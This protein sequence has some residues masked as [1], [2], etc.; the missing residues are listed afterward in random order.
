MY[1]AI[2]FFDLDGTL[3]LNDKSLSP[4]VI[5]AIGQLKANNILPV[6]STG[7]NVFEVEYVL[8]QTG[9]NSIVSA[10]G[11]YVEYE[12][13]EL[14]AD[15]M[16][17]SVINEFNA[18]AKKQGDPVAWF[19][20]AEF[21]LSEETPVTDENFKLLSLD[22]RVIPDWYEKNA[23]NFLFVF[24][25][26]KEELYQER[27]AGKLSLVRNNPRGLDT[28]VAGVSKKT[29]IQQ[30]LKYSGLGEIPSYA[31][32]DQINDLEM[33]DQVDHPVAM[34]NGNPINKERAEFVTTSNMDNGI[35]NGLKHF[36]LI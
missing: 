18:F 5:E 29:G 2:V 17:E 33:F 30:L 32:G 26:D 8:E 7:R 19:N 10:N 20:H 25:F 35:V 4:E 1:K 6:V 36:D 28:M 21:A 3:L 23:V 24:N 27:F 15:Y 34:G 9:M 13:K 14:H 11:S 31:F 12:G 22:A 16:T